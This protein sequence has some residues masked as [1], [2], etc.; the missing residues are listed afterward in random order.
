MHPN[1][2]LYP[3]PGLA[4]IRFGKS[5]RNYL[6]RTEVV[7]LHHQ[8]DSEWPH[9]VRVAFV[10]IKKRHHANEEGKAGLSA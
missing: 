8:S 2:V 4:V 7:C 3:T 5:P 1:I 6:D 9:S 10:R